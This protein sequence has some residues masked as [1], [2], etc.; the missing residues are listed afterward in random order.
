M[1]IPLF[2][3][4]LQIGFIAALNNRGYRSNLSPRFVNPGQT[5]RLPEPFNYMSLS[6]RGI[7]ESDEQTDSEYSNSVEDYSFRSVRPLQSRSN[8]KSNDYVNYDARPGIDVSLETAPVRRINSDNY[9]NGLQQTSQLSRRTGSYYRRPYLRNRSSNLPLSYLSQNY[10]KANDDSSLEFSSVESSS[11]EDAS[12]LGEEAAYLRS[13][14]SLIEQP[15]N[16]RGQ[17]R[18]YYRQGN[19]LSID[20]SPMDQFNSNDDA[21]NSLTDSFNQRRNHNQ[22]YTDSILLVNNQPTESPQPTGNTLYNRRYDDE[23]NLDE[24]FYN[25][26]FHGPKLGQRE[27]NDSPLIQKFNRKSNKNAGDESSLNDELITDGDNAE[28]LTVLR[29]ASLEDLKRGNTRKNNHRN[30]LRLSLSPD[31]KLTLDEGVASDLSEILSET[32]DELNL[33]PAN[34]RKIDVTSN[35]DSRKENNRNI[36]E[37]DNINNMFLLRLRN[38]DN[39]NTASPIRRYDKLIYR[40]KERYVKPHRNHKRPPPEISS[41]APP[42]EP[43][44]PIRP[45]GKRDQRTRG[46]GNFVEYFRPHSTRNLKTHGN[47]TRQDFTKSFD[48][49]TTKTPVHHHRNE[50]NKP[51]NHQKHEKQINNSKDNANF[52]HDE[53]SQGLKK[54]GNA[55]DDLSVLPPVKN[56]NLTPLFRSSDGILSKNTSDKLHLEF[57][58]NNQ[59]SPDDDK[60][61]SQLRSDDKTDNTKDNTLNLEFPWNNAQSS[62]ADKDKSRLRSDE[63]E[64][65]SK[66]TT[67]ALDLEFPWNGA[68]SSD[69]GKSESQLRTDE[70]EDK[71]KDT[72]DTLDLD[73]P[74]NGAPSS[75]AD[76]NKSRLRTDE[77]KYE[78]KD[79]T[80][81]LDLQ[82]PWNGASSP[83]AGK[84]KS[85]LRA[86]ERKDKSKDTKDTLDLEFPW[87]GA[88]SHDAD[89]STSQLR[90]EKHK[91][92]N[93]DNTDNL[94]LEFPWND[95]LSPDSN[96][97]KSQLRADVA[98]DKTKN[99]T[100]ELH[101][102][103]PWNDVLSPNADKSKSQLRADSNMENTIDNSN[104]LDLGYPWNDALSPDSHES[105]SPLRG[106]GDTKDTTDTLNLEYP[107]NEQLSPDK[108]KREGQKPQ[109]PLRGQ[110]DNS[111]D[112][113]P[114]DQLKLGYP[115]NDQTSPDEPSSKPTPL[116]IPDPFFIHPYL[117][118]RNIKT[119][120]TYFIRSYD[121][122]LE[123]VRLGKPHKKHRRRQLKRR[124]NDNLGVSGLAGRSNGRRRLRLRRKENKP[125]LATIYGPKY[126]KSVIYRSGQRGGGETYNDTIIF[127]KD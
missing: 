35:Q 111:K 65:I 18:K 28:K 113:V 26:L 22:A 4:V 14:L 29:L 62:D 60:S 122:F 92:Q 36:V 67:D 87:N 103:Y 25:S 47:H 46:D 13:L 1:D 31:N 115:W 64:D 119:H 76:K 126:I 23:L 121:D 42:P 123:K 50:S 58:W 8:L 54:E 40:S 59:M 124:L 34:V 17:S 55:P 109:S 85:Q 44:E 99:S 48:E 81:T 127:P 37:E 114:L 120:P 20:M 5:R 69:A 72:S 104:S 117:R 75:H 6:S 9:A 11:F 89:K 84:G 24:D 43:V 110:A 82:F 56:E 38:L 63:G 19:S 116:R 80:D 73:F 71:S 100:D 30:F 49:Y 27:T 83:D 98:K 78:S 39:P 88:S 52:H 77:Q 106:K 96:Q 90:S 16:R 21:A 94:H 61:E 51:L 66:D 101:L 33:K 7:P 102:E 118:N 70:I 91:I 95:A 12:R 15:S 105:K 125:E 45:S 86:D 79:S 107:W 74:W 2:V 32:L 10:R 41:E 3:L 53:F 93:K 108:T 68:P 97:G 112:K 57:P